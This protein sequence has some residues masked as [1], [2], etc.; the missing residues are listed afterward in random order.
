LIQLLNIQNEENA[1]LESDQD[2]DI[3]SEPTPKSSKKQ[4]P[5]DAV[6]N[7]VMKTKRDCFYRNALP[8]NA[9]LFSEF[10]ILMHAF[11]PLFF[12][13]TLRLKMLQYLMRHFYQNFDINCSIFSR[14]VSGKK[15]VQC[16][17]G[18]G[19]TKSKSIEE[20]IFKTEKLS[21]NRADL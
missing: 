12:P 15:V 5:N 20:F 8:P 7:A 18:Q 9:A 1:I 10:W 2:S 13:D 6:C 11:N 19:I 14:S 17:M 21:K 3:E 4:K 16:I